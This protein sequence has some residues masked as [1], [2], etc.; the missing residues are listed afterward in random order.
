MLIR[1][2]G[3]LL[4][5]TEMILTLL[6]MVPRYR[7]SSTEP[8]TD[9]KK[10]YSLEKIL[11]MWMKPFKKIKNPNKKKLDFCNRKKKSQSVLKE[12][13]IHGKVVIKNLNYANRNKKLQL[14]CE[15]GDFLFRIQ[16]EKVLF[17]TFQYGRA[18]SEVFIL[19]WKGC[20]Y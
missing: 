11:F 17:I 13:S 3:F 20:Y 5:M 16:M 1:S 2:D 18:Q 15:L 7:R 12:K 14:F 19:F 8:S 4:S 6:P 10:N 9:W